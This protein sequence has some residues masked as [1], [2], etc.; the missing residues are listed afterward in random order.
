V[1]KSDFALVNNYIC[2][3]LESGVSTKFKKK[4]LEL[5]MRKSK[6]QI[7]ILTLGLLTTGLG[8]WT[9]LQIP[10]HI[11]PSWYLVL[12][13]LPITLLV[14]FG[15]GFLI[16]SLFKIRWHTLTITSIIMAVTCLS[17]YI[18]E[19]RPSHTINI[20]NNY[21]GEV[22]LLVTDEANNDFNINEFGIGYINQNT[23]EN[24]FRPTVIKDKENITKQIR[25]YSRGAFVS[26]ETHNISLEFVTFIVPGNKTTIEY[27][28]IEELIDKKA[29][30]TTRILRK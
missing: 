24:G 8:V 12:I 26:T 13:F 30:D 25:S 3:V 11:L 27:F 15:L 20:P 2:D 7:A 1:K 6:V 16:K 21:V 5:Q 22:K 18:S 19:F 4:C 28:S 9:M 17:F 10:T 14:A 29:I 23:F